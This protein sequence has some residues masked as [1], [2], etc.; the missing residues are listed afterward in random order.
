MWSTKK[1]SE[2]NLATDF[3]Y[4]GISTVRYLE[5]NIYDIVNH[6]NNCKHLLTEVNTQTIVFMNRFKNETI[7]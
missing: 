2:S 4:I 6:S 5:L 3:E 1:K 7:Y